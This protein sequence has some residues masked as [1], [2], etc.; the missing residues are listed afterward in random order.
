M[1][2]EDIKKNY[3][4]TIFMTIITVLSINASF[5]SSNFQYID[6][7]LYIVIMI[8]APYL[9]FISYKEHKK[10]LEFYRSPQIK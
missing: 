2:K 5:W 4:N 6:Y 10:L 8:S 9:I 3:H 7:I 1:H